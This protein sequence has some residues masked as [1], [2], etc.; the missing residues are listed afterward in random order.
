MFE[1]VQSPKGMASNSMI[2]PTYYSGTSPE[3][4]GP[5]PR[6]LRSGGMLGNRP[7]CL[8]TNN[9]SIDIT[10]NNL[11]SFPRHNTGS[12]YKPLFKWRRYET[13]II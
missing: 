6:I 12:T 3:S 4:S 1:G 13:T 11:E 2:F 5:L 8:Y 9:K 10:K 7:V